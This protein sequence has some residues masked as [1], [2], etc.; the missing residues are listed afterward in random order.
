MPTWKDDTLLL[1]D[2]VIGS[3]FQGRPTSRSRKPH[4]SFAISPLDGTVYN[5]SNRGVWFDD[6]DEAIAAAE[7]YVAAHPGLF[8]KPE[9][10]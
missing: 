8:V 5:A 7:E 1:D 6:K 2:A 10:E 4:W 9:E 3:I